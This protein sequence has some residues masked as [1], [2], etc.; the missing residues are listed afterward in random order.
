MFTCTLPNKWCGL[1]SCLG[2]WGCLLWHDKLLQK[3][4]F[5]ARITELPTIYTLFFLFSLGLVNIVFISFNQRL[6]LYYCV[7][8]LWDEGL[9]S[10]PFFQDV[11]GPKYKRKQSAW[12]WMTDVDGRHDITMSERYVAL[13]ESNQ[14]GSFPPSISI[15]KPLT[16]LGRTGVIC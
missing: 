8:G 13:P 1:G 10:P 9:L 6:Y 2:R 15:R 12:G 3:L 7:G 5:H 11:D 16:W 14:V 4:T